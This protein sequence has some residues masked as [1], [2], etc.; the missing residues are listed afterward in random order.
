MSFYQEKKQPFK[1]GLLGYDTL[2]LPWC[3]VAV[4]PRSWCREPGLDPWSG[5]MLCGALKEEKTS[6]ESNVLVCQARERT[7]SHCLQT[8]LAWAYCGAFRYVLIVEAFWKEKLLLDS[9][10]KPIPSE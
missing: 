7:R 3:P 6:G 1:P 5:H 10:T 8:R 2:G 4:T 9:L